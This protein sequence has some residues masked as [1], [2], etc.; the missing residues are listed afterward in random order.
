MK[1]ITKYTLSALSI[2]AL[3]SSTSFAATDFALLD[4][5]VVDYQTL[6]LVFNNELSDDMSDFQFDISLEENS[7]IRVDVID[8]QRINASD[9]QVQLANDLITNEAYKLT[10]LWAADIDGDGIES[11]ID[12]M[13]TF[14]VPEFNNVFVDNTNP[15]DD[16][17]ANEADEEFYA[18]LDDDTQVILTEDAT[19]VA[20]ALPE[21]WAKEVFVVF[22]AMILAGWLMYGVRRLRS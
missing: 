4:V 19:S 14:V 12:S 7:D 1:K 21:T 3:L 15:F 16:L 6:H 8:V 11:G 9:L 13:A 10:V 17:S 20:E 5:N 22:L 2:V 18:A